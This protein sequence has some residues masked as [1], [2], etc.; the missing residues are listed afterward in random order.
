[1][2]DRYKGETT[3]RDVFAN[4]DLYRFFYLSF[5][6]SQGVPSAQYRIFSWVGTQGFY[7]DTPK[8]LPKD[9]QEKLKIPLLHKDPTTMNSPDINREWK[10]QWEVMGERLAD[11]G[12][13]SS[14]GFITAIT[15]HM[16]DSDLAYMFK[17]RLGRDKDAKFSEPDSDQDPNAS[18]IRRFAIMLKPTGHVVYDKMFLEISKELKD[19]S[20]RKDQK[21]IDLAK[22]WE[23]IHKGHGFFVNLKHG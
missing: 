5:K 20:I 8:T 11:P 13:T 2:N 7:P 15:R 6:F 18:F 1:M 16:I 14:G 4:K 23:E 3:E 12:S 9:F 21:T 22:K 17:N 19:K 10:K